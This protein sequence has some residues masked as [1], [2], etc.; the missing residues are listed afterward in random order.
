[1]VTQSIGRCRGSIEQ[2]LRDRAGRGQIAHLP[3]GGGSS[4]AWPSDRASPHRGGV[5]HAVVAAMFSAA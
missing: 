1:M 4:L 3:G 5:R 2:R